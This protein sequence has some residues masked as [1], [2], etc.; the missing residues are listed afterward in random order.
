MMD[1]ERAKHLLNLRLFE[2]G[3]PIPIRDESVEKM[4]R[5]GVILMVDRTG[6]ENDLVTWVKPKPLV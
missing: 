1:F 3:I 4:M 5:E 2:C 6:P